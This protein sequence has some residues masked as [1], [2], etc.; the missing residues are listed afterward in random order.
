MPGPE[1]GAG[2]EGTRL[3]LCLDWSGVG[4]G[5]EQ[6]RAVPDH[7]D[8]R[9]GEDRVRVPAVVTDLAGPRACEVRGRRRCGCVLLIVGRDRQ[10]RAHDPTAYPSDA[11]DP[12][13]RGIQWLSNCSSGVSGS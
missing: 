13:T 12:I 4:P 10:F 9:I 2:D 8:A 11:A 6:L 3:A 7:V 1:A 5:D